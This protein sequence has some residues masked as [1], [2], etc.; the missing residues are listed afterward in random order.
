MGRR[1]GHTFAGE[2]AVG[3]VTKWL[4]QAGGG[5]EEVWHVVYDDG[6]GEDL[7]KAEM[8]AALMVRRVPL[9]LL[10]QQPMPSMSQNR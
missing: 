5:E 10:A 9:S 7:D 6:D 3:R 4:E 2:L 8:E 1:V